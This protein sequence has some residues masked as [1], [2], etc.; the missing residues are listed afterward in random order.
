MT[1]P[2]GTAR[3]VPAGSRL[4]F[5]MHYTPNGVEQ[6]DRTSVGLLF[7]E[8]RNV[9]RAMKADMAVNVKFRIPPGDSNYQTSAE[10]RFGQDTILYALYPHMHLRGKSFKIEAIYPDQKRQLLL[11]V[12]RYRFDW[13][14]RYA[15][16]QPL[17]AF[18]K[19][20]FFIATPNLI[21]RR[22]ISPIRTP[23][24]RF[25]LVSRPEMK[26]WWV[27]STWPWPTRT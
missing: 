16:A 19:G 3:F 12:P 7:A 11:D 13:Q 6:I 22:R 23:R 10:Y 1:F 5:Q 4:V 15:L 25:T 27:T 17:T 18:L 26:C 9:K 24:P 14:N 21:I 8:P 20:P 2:E